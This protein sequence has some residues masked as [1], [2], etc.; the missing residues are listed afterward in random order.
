MAGSSVAEKVEEV[1]SSV[2]ATWAR[3]LAAARTVVGAHMERVRKGSFSLIERVV[4]YAVVNP[5]NKDIGK[6]RDALNKAIKEEMEGA[7][8]KD[9][10]S[11]ELT[12]KDSKN[13]LLS[14]NDKGSI[15]LRHG[16]AVLELRPATSETLV[17]EEARTVLAEKGLLD[18]AFVSKVAV[19]DPARLIEAVKDAIAYL[20]DLEATGQME[21]LCEALEASTTAEE[22]FSEAKIQDF[23]TEGRLTV[24]DIVPMFRTT[25]SYK[26]YEK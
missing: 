23:I 5:I 10:E 25:Y 21:A 24:D 13:G 9:A 19:T 12:L 4:L 15:F 20:N 11:G 17:D 16:E 26:L 22:V 14:Q 3:N 18:G 7:C 8:E 1:I 2:T 6:M